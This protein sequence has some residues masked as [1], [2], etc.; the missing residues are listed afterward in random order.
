MGL[1]VRRR[2]RSP[3]RASACA[4]AAYGALFGRALRTLHARRRSGTAV[5]KPQFMRDFDLTSR[6]YNAV[7]FTLEGME[8]SL[9]ELRPV[10]IADLKHRLKAVAKKVANESQPLKMHHLKRRMAFLQMRLDNLQKASEPHLCFGSRKLFNAQHH[11]AQNQGTL[12]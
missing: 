9:R 12:E 7:T 5:T 3:A 10:H 8:S 11:L 6:E 1:P 4:L 2:I